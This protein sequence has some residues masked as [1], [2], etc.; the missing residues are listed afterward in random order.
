M[1]PNDSKLYI[2]EDKR[3]FL[4][5]D[6]ALYD[7]YICY[8]RGG[9]DI[10]DPSL[11]LNFQTWYLRYEELKF[12]LRSEDG[13]EFVLKTLNEDINLTKLT[14]SFDQN[15]KLAWGYSQ[16]VPNTEINNSTFY[17]YNTRVDDYDE[18]KL[19]N[20]RDI[21]VKL[22]DLR[23]SSNR[24]ND[25]I[26]SYIDIEGWL[27]IRYQR[28]RYLKTIRMLKVPPH[29]VVTRVGLTRDYRLQFELR[30]VNPVKHK[31]NKFLLDTL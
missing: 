2:Q 17:W 29:S 19:P 26:L 8:E 5:L 27:C 7:P 13:K 23:L 6:S 20:T 16:K 12:I 1:L 14:F 31:N 21:S 28:E 9:V 30:A 18:I 25:I 11:G 3:E 22:D 24:F 4:Y 15:M 10:S